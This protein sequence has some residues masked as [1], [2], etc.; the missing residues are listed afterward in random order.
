MSA[1]KGC[2]GPEQMQNGKVQEL[3]LNTGRAV[4]FQCDKGYDLV[5]DSLVVC[6]GGNTWSS[7]FPTCQ[8]ENTPL[9]TETCIHKHSRS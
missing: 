6:M 9:L 3:S 5:G 7:S 1:V 2:D 8:R 4:E